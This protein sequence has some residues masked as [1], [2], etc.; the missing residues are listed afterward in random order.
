MVSQANTNTTRPETEKVEILGVA[1]DRVDR[2]GAA[3]FIADA[4]ARFHQAKAAGSAL[5]VLAHIVTANSEIVML[6]K[7]Q[8]DVADILCQAALV[9]P[10]GIGLVWGS[11]ILGQPLTERVPGIELMEAMLAKCAQTGWRPFF[12]GAAPGVAEEAKAVVEQRY[13]G[14]QVAGVHHGYFNETEIPRVLQIIRETQPDLLLVALGAPRQERW[15]ATYRDQLEVPVGVGVG[16][17]LDIWSGRSQRAPQ[18]MCDMG[19]EWLYRLL[20]Q[21]TRTRRMLALPR[22]A[23][24]VWRERLTRR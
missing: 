8:S 14:L 18:W 20:R 17:S 4:I 21:P 2:N 3:Q 11:R 15:I 16:G 23:F 13:P 10:D 24:A 7:Q 12:L 19:L 1:V 5:P 22:F 9:V 6:A